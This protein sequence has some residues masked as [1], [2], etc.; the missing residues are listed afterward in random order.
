MF[1]CFR[2]DLKERQSLLSRALGCATTCISEQGAWVG[3]EVGLGMGGSERAVGP[4][5]AYSLQ[6]QLALCT[7]QMKVQKGIEKWREKN[8][9]TQ[10]PFAIS[11]SSVDPF[12]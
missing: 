1:V 4:E 12:F 5:E 11:S 2:Y 8:P 6:R 7:I 9:P 3:Q 10:V